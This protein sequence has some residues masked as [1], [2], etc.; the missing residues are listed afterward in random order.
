M[1][2]MMQP[3]Y[4]PPIHP[5]G[6]T[7]GI[8]MTLNGPPVMNAPPQPGR[9]PPFDVQHPPGPSPRIP[10]PHGQGPIGMPH[11]H[12]PPGTVTPHRVVGK[13]GLLLRQNVDIRSPQV[14]DQSI[15]EGTNVF[16]ADRKGDRVLILGTTMNGPMA[17]IQGW[18][19]I[20]SSTGYKI[21]EEIPPGSS[22][23]S[24]SHPPAPRPSPPRPGPVP[25]G[26]LHSQRPPQP[27]I[28]VAPMAPISRPHPAIP[29]MARPTWGPPGP[30]MGPTPPSLS[31]PYRLTPSA[32]SAPPPMQ[33]HPTPAQPPRPMPSAMMV[34]GPPGPFGA[35]SM[36][37]WPGQRSNSPQ[38]P[39]PPPPGVQYHAPQALHRDRPPMPGH[40]GWPTPGP[41]PRGPPPRSFYEGYGPGGR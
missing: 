26:Y 7:P 12:R 25:P 15:P 39:M 8:G 16:V 10:M 19:S 17:H 29:H 41:M 9:R 32:M 37:R 30:A 6:P 36:P 5:P 40:P 35:P 27:P 3:P 18:G 23:S 1:Q 28:Q 31:P 34:H 38:G 33:M 13:L 14:S 24:M 2:H 11:P 22:M 4:G 21:L 20:R